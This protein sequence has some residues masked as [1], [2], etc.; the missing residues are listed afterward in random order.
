MLNYL[1]PGKILNSHAD[2]QPISLSK[3]KRDN[4]VLHFFSELLISCLVSLSYSL[5]FQHLCC[6]FN[7]K[8]STLIFVGAP[9]LYMYSLRTLP[10]PFP[11]LSIVSRIHFKFT[12]MAQNPLRNKEFGRQWNYMAARLQKQT[13]YL[14]FCFLPFKEALLSGNFQGIIYLYIS[15]C[16]QMGVH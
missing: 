6:V 12:Y 13:R 2:H 5:P 1:A 16:S 4:P 10:W 15:T 7:G 14:D 11:S 3:G 8:R 9:S